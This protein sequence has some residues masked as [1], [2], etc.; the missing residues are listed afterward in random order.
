MKVLSAL[1]LVLLSV[2]SLSLAD[3]EVAHDE[4]QSSESLDFDKMTSEEAAGTIMAFLQGMVSI[5]LFVILRS[6]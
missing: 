4:K 5:F 2:A 6:F 3:T 1:F